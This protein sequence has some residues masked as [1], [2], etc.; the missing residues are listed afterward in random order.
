MSL[1]SGTGGLEGRPSTVTVRSSW[2]TRI[3][4]TTQLGFLVGALIVVPV[5]AL[6][7]GALSNNALGGT[8]ALIA[9]VAVFVAYDIMWVALR[10][11][12]RVDVGPSGVVFHF[13][14]HK[15]RRSWN[16]LTPGARPASKNGWILQ[17]VPPGRGYL[18]TIPQARAIA[19]R[20]EAECWNLSNDVRATLGL[21][22]AS[23]T[24]PREAHTAAE[25]GTATSLASRLVPRLIRPFIA[26]LILFVVTMALLEASFSTGSADW[27]LAA[28]AGAFATAGVGGYVIAIYLQESVRRRQNLRAGSTPPSGGGGGGSHLC[29]SCGALA[30][31]GDT[32]CRHCGQKLHHG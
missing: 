12:R 16:A 9:L 8:I 1:S 15:D 27:R 30:H 22:P 3:N 5:F 7:T 2:L 20:P 10:W 14:F 6:A 29:A 32:F 18:L 24:S 28:W 4:L 23:P 19:G 13:M 31:P 11:V 25:E 17:S 26:I 21:A